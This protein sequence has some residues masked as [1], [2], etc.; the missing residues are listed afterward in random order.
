LYGFTDNYIR[1][2]IPFSKEFLQQ[3]L[4]IKLLSFDE[5]ANILSKVI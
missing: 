4:K 3:K 1:V 2:K 5:N